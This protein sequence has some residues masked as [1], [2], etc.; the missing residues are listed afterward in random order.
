MERL[1]LTQSQV[2][3]LIAH[4]QS[5]MPNEA[6]G[7]LGGVDGRVLGV[8]PTA[9]A[10]N[11]PTRYL[12]QPEDL[13]AALQEMEAQGWGVDPIAIYHSHP[14]GPETPSKTDVEEAHYPDSVY[15]IIAF[16]NRQYPSVRGFRIRDGEINQVRL[17]I[18]SNNNE[19]A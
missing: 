16:P 17:T 2:D 4:A 10:L 13:L 14:R 1:V 9:N 15:I 8:F 6:C 7:L 11:S 3:Q 5:E 18:L 12:V 19:V